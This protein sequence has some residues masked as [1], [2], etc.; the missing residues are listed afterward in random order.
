MGGSDVTQGPRRAW[1]LPVVAFVCAAALAGAF[2]LHARF[3]NDD[4]LITIRYAENLIQ[5][6]GLVY[7]PGERALG[8]TT[9]LWALLLAGLGALGA[10]VPT[11]ATVLGVLAHGWTTAAT[12]LLFRD[13]GSPM[14][15]QAL[16]GGL[17]GTS[18]ALLTWAGAGMETAAYVA[19]MATFLWLF[20]RERWALLGWVAGAMALLRP[21]SGLVMLAA[22]VLVVARR[23]TIR[24]LLRAA[25][26][27]LVMVVPWLVGAAWYYGSPLPNSGFAKRLQVEDWGTY[28]GR[29]WQHLWAVQ[30]LLPFALVGLVLAVLRPARALPALALV[31]VV[32]GMHA[33]GLPGCAWYLVPPLYL[34]CVL[35]AEGAAALAER[36]ADGRA[37]QRAPLALAVAAGP[38]LAHVDIVRDVHDL[39][40]AQATIERCHG[41]IGTWLGEHAP[42]DASV[43]VDN[44]GYIGYRSGLR[45]IDMLGLV[46]PEIAE[47]IA[48][49]RRD[50]AL[51]HH[52]PELIAM[53]VGR[54]NTWKYTPDQAWFDE[55]GYRKVFAAPLRD[56]KPEPAYTIFSRIPLGER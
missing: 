29:F 51:R 55:N 19:A 8:T 10:N 16:A 9:P 20:E 39:K 28:I 54:G 46:Q 45:V 4:A 40:I 44:I 30:A 21:D 35:A 37:L 18:S 33:G 53:W 13:R 1:A 42:R 23:R 56:D 49:G 6:K 5:G 34:V 48:A 47:Q 31:T 3:F 26:G 7:N 41:T 50:Y 27:F 52:R 2:F 11:A 32:G 43:G 15:A 38:F 25:P 14:W 22:C 36:M 24:P 17:V 12:V